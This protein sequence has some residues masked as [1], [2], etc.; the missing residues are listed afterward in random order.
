MLR[1]YLRLHVA[2]LLGA[3]GR[4]TSQPVAS[5]LTV[6]VIAIAIALPA[7]LRVFVANVGTLT[8]N[9]QSA[10]DITVYLEPGTGDD[11]A[12]ALADRLGGRPDVAA[13]R[14]IAAAAAL[15]EFRQRSGFGEALDA[16]S[17]NPLP[18]TI[19]VSPADGAAADVGEMRDALA[20]EPGVELVQIDT[21]WVARLRAML[22]LIGRISNIATGL[23][24]AAVVLVIGNTIRLEINNR[25]VEIEVMKL[26]GGTDGFIRRPFLY[27]GLWYG[28]LGALVA[29]LLVAI[30]LLLL[31]GPVGELARLY[32]S[33]FGLRGLPLRDS[34]LLVAGGAAL[35]WA[36]AWV[37]A[38]R[39]L[40]TIEPA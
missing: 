28:A 4:L 25:R 34:L 13:V 32:A 33:D 31:A 16:L 11:E 2:N 23:L 18:H 7:G 38:A 22:S 19:V 40:R 12:Q 10:A 20:R 6:L 24:A 17:D 8:S 30:A 5:T 36:G 37:A 1:R 14:L 9:W 3:A 27:L 15:E 21:E 26:V 39:H 29:W 35:G